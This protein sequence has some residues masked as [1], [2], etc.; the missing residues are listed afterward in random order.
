[1]GGKGCILDTAT[2][3]TA[4]LRAGPGLGAQHVTFPGA[5]VSACQAFPNQTTKE[6]KQKASFIS[7]NLPL[8]SESDSL[9]LPREN[10][11]FK[12]HD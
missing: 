8:S 1:M 7:E 12:C 2:Q 10:D 3:Q 6:E 9:R 11:A 5:R 4:A